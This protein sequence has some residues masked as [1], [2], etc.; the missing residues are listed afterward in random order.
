MIKLC[1]IFMIQNGILLKQPPEDEEHIE[2]D[3][4]YHTEDVEECLNLMWDIAELC[5]I[6]EKVQIK[7]AKNTTKK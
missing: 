4:S 3:N 6:N 5:C 2:L 7:K 1:E